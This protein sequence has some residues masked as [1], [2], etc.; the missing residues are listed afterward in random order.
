M[1]R[2]ALPPSS[3]GNAENFR[4]TRVNFVNFARAAR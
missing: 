4:I 3:P 2:T 1:N